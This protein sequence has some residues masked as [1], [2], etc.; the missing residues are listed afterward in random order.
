MDT[1]FSISLI[2]TIGAFVLT[3]YLFVVVVSVQGHVAPVDIVSESVTVSPDRQQQ[4]EHPGEKIFKANCKACHRIDRQLIG[5]ALG[6]VLDR[7]DSLWVISMIR[8]SSKLIASG[9]PTA[10]ELFKEYNGTQMTSF[11]SFTDEELRSLL[12]YLKLQGKRERGPVP[13]PARV[14]V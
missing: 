12:E 9:D 8:N 14:E 5:P 3:V 1:R 11:S 6:G 4:I 7:R 13:S 2:M 10:V